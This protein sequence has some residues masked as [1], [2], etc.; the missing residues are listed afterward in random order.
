VEAKKEK[1]EAF[2]WATAKPL[3]TKTPLFL[4]QNPTFYVTTIKWRATPT[5]VNQRVLKNSGVKRTLEVTGREKE[6]FL[7]Q[8]FRP[9]AMDGRDNS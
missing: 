9:C 1:K 5:T 6:G 3:P 2:L 4:G 8:Q 7:A